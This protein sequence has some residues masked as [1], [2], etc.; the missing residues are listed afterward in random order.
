MS[1]RVDSPESDRPREDV[2]MGGMDDV[3]AQIVTDCG[4]LAFRCDRSGRIEYI[5]PV[6]STVLGK[7]SASVLGQQLAD[8]LPSYPHTPSGSVDALRAVFEQAASTEYRFSLTS[9]GFQ[10]DYLVLMSPAAAGM[11]GEVK[12]AH[13]L[14]VDI[15]CQRQKVREA[16]EADQRKERFLAF[17]A[18]EMRNPLTS[19]ASGVRVLARQ[20]SLEQF[21]KVAGMMDRQVEYLS[22]LVSDLLDIARNNHGRMVISKREVDVADVVLHALE[23]SKCAVERGK[24]RLKV[25]VPQYAIT[26]HGDLQRLSQVLS[27]LIDNAA[28]YTPE[29]GEIAVAVTQD[30]D[31]AVMTVSDNGIGISEDQLPHIFEMFRQLH[32]VDGN[33]DGGLGIGLFLVKMIVESHQGSIQAHSLGKDSGSSFVVRLPLLKGDSISC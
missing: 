1:D 10:R 23:S 22:R 14:V 29:G 18:H 33:R 27:N 11:N 3:V 13:G 32:G 15:S 31:E 16:R 28:K 6:C 7:P 5:N 4:V 19:I 2:R 9:E 20:P 26:V 30:G 25:S 21:K 17:V 24:H 8:I 12:H